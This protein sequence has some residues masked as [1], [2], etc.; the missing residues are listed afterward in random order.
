M[1]EVPV[2]PERDPPPLSIDQVY[3]PPHP[4]EA[5][6]VC[7]PLV[8]ICCDVNPIT[9]GPPQTGQLTN[10][11][12]M[13]QNTENGSIDKFTFLFFTGA[14]IVAP[15]SMTVLGGSL[16]ALPKRRIKISKSITPTLPSPS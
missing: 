8:A 16:L 6:K 11:I 13:R 7:V 2:E 10:I 3:G 4:P 14:A 12:P 5:V 1:T 15:F 9:G